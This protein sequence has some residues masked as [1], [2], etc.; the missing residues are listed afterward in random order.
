MVGLGETREYGF[1]GWRAV[2]H[3]SGA[4]EKKWSRPS[5]LLLAEVLGDARL[6]MPMPSLRWR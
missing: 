3:P 5:A 1:V 4:R 6:M 2:R